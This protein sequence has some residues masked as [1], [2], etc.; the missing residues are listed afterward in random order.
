MFRLMFIASLLALLLSSAALA[1]DK[2]TWEITR[3][4]E[5]ETAIENAL[6]D[7][8]FRGIGS[9]S[10][11][12]NWLSF[13]RDTERDAIDNDQV[14]AYHIDDRIVRCQDVRNELDHHESHSWL[15]DSSGFLL[16][17]DWSRLLM[18]SDIWY[19]DVANETLRNLTD[20]NVRGNALFGDDR[21]AANLD[22]A[23]IA[24]PGTDNIYFFR[25]LLGTEQTFIM[26]MTL[27]DTEPTR[28]LDVTDMIG[29]LTYTGTHTIDF[30]PDGS[31]LVMIGQDRRNN[32]STIWVVDVTDEG[33]AAQDDRTPI[34]DFQLFDDDTGDATG[35]P[36]IGWEGT[37]PLFPAEVRWQG[38]E[39]LAFFAQTDITPLFSMN[40]FT[41]DLAEDRLT[42][43]LD[44]DQFPTYEDYDSSPYILPIGGVSDPRTGTLFYYLANFDENRMEVFTLPNDPEGG[45]GVCG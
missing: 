23:A 41:Y 20:D 37:T 29:P 32:R 43:A 8:T 36:S 7:D 35:F 2:T 26:R 11:D 27:D 44:S 1:Q 21:E 17:E 33:I 40:I 31:Q 18:E 22:Y 4:T 14:C 30:S 28:I 3:V 9:L 24:Q 13:N 10:P 25:S 16:H 12:G 42:P 38:N 19:F 45:A 15:L 39:R 34:F 5:M 6:G